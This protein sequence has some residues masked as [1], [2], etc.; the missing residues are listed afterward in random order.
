L[1]FRQEKPHKF[2][3]PRT[4]PLVQCRSAPGLPDQHH[5][6]SAQNLTADDYSDAFRD[7][8]YSAQTQGCT[9]LRPDADGTTLA[10]LLTFYW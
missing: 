3:A 7:L 9:L 4:D 5:C 10:E 8:L 1:T 6:E 2:R